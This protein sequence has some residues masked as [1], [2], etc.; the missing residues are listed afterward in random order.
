MA[1]CLYFAYHV[2][3]SQNFME[4]MHMNKIDMNRSALFIKQ[5]VIN[6]SIR[7]NAD[8]RNMGNDQW[9]SLCIRT[10]SLR[11]NSFRANTKTE[12]TKIE[13]RQKKSHKI[14]DRK[15]LSRF[16]DLINFPFRNLVPGTTETELKCF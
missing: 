3:C 2:F 4:T 11:T 5:N 13:S 8:R 1:F 15:N 10:P 12:T 16:L 9:F 7:M 6:P 14:R